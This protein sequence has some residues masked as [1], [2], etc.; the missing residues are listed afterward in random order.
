MPVGA[1]LPPVA[2]LVQKLSTSRASLDKAYNILEAAGVIRRKPG[3]GVFVADPTESGRIAIVVR[4]EAM[5]W[6]MTPFQR[7]AAAALTN[8][9]HLAENQLTARLDMGQPYV[10][11]KTFHQTLDLNDPAE[12]SQLRGVFTHDRLGDLLQTLEQERIPVI[13][14]FPNIAPYTVTYASEDMLHAGMRHLLDCGSKR[15]A[16]A[17]A[18]YGQARVNRLFEQAAIPESQRLTIYCDENA[19]ERSGYEKFVKLWQ[20]NKRPD[21]V[22]ACTDVHCAGILRAA[23]QLRINMPESLKLVSFAVDGIE[24]PYHEPVTRVTFN[25][26]ELADTAMQMMMKLVKGQS[27]RRKHEIIPFC[28]RQ[29]ATT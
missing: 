27:L 4:H 7:M 22:L 25:I 19:P 24:L 5:H 9:I 17:S 29:G 21:G 15:I 8:Q 23:L 1:A 16:I 3:A 18:D 11:Q 6:Q 20:S 10:D 12:R 26:E 28:L 14:L 2:E 13:G